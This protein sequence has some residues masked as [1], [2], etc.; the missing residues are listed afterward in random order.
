ME[1]SDLD[2]EIAAATQELSVLLEK[3]INTPIQNNF[4]E[5]AHSLSIDLK[6]DIGEIVSSLRKNIK[7]IKDDLE[8]LTSDIDNY[9]KKIKNLIEETKKNKEYQK[10]NFKNT[11]AII[12]ESS[13]LTREE[14]VGA[15][16]RL[17]NISNAQIQN[18]SATI[19]LL[20]ENTTLKN[21]ENLHYKKEIAEKL[22]EIAFTIGAYEGLFKNTNAQIIESSR[23]ISGEIAKIEAHLSVLETT[24]LQPLN[25]ALQSLH[26]DIQGNSK[27]INEYYKYINPIIINTNELI[28]QNN[29]ETMK[30]NSFPIKYIAFI[31]TINT[32]AIIFL[33][34]FTIK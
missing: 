20:H 23:L 32:I 4:K 24:Q 22:K 28:K 15:E 17:K 33:T 2:D 14:I 3:N 11:D 30:I 31:I 34:Y 18:L 19:E 26:V 9:D 12:I 10:S 8:E 1:R 16:E 29:M 13:Q 6:N 27:E 25:S 5:I 7:D 21:N